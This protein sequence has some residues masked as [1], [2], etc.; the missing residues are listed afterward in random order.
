MAYTGLMVLPVDPPPS[1]PS[2]A[3]SA[4]LEGLSGLLPAK[5]TRNWWLFGA[6]CLGASA[7]IVGG[8]WLA[9]KP[10]AALA[11][12]AVLAGR[13]VEAEIDVRQLGPSGLELGQLRLGSIESPTV[14]LENAQ[15]HWFWNKDKGQIDVRLSS[16]GGLK[17]NI[18][19]GKG[20]LDLGALGPLLESDATGR[21]PVF[22]ETIKIDGAEVIVATQQGPI[23][24]KVDVAGSQDN[25]QITGSALL[26][27][28]LTG[29]SG[30]Q[31][32]PLS[33]VVR[34]LPKA[35]IA[36][37][38]TVIGFEARPEG[39]VYDR[40]GVS[41]GAVTGR[42]AGGVR[43]E[44]GTAPIITLKSSQLR[45]G[46]FSGF[47]LT[48]AN[49]SLDLSSLT[50]TQADLWQTRAS[51][52]LD[53]TLTA[54]RA[55]YAGVTAGALR[56][57]FKAARSLDA[58]LT[59]TYDLSA[60]L[61][62]VPGGAIDS[63]GS[64]R[65]Q[66]TAEGLLPDIAA[67]AN[68]SL[69]FT[70]SLAINRLRLAR[71][72]IATLPEP[73]AAVIGGPVAVQGQIDG[74]YKPGRFEL[75]LAAPMQF[76]GT[77]HSGVFRPDRSF[78]SGLVFEAAGE[79]EA[80]GSWS[81]TGGLRGDLEG[82]ASGGSY[83]ARIET[84]RITEGLF[85]LQLGPVRWDRLQSGGLLTSG[86]LQNG[87]LA[88]A[89]GRISGQG[90]GS[91]SASGR[92]PD[93]SVIDGLSGQFSGQ[94]DANRW[95]GRFDGRIGSFASR[96]VDA[97]NSTGLSVSNVK[98]NANLNGRRRPNGTMLAEVDADAT[99]ETLQFGVTR[100]S[101]AT[102]RTR[103]QAGSG[104]DLFEGQT[105]F[106]A[107]RVTSPDLSSR[108]IAVSGP[109]SIRSSNGGA[110]RIG[111]DLDGRA[112][113]TSTSAGS[114]ATSTVRADGAMVLEGATTT[115]VIRADFV[116]GD[117]RQGTNRVREIT[118]SNRFTLQAGRGSFS[119]TS[120]SG[121]LPA[122]LSGISA[123]EGT[124]GQVGLEICPEPGRPLLSMGGNRTRLA[125][126]A[127]ISPLDLQL[128]ANADLPEGLRQS[129]RLGPSRLRVVDSPQGQ[130]FVLSTTSLEYLLPLEAGVAASGP[131]EG[132]ASA[133]VP[134][135]APRRLASV[136]SNDANVEITPG[137]GGVSIVATLNNVN[138]NGLPVN[139][140]GSATANLLFSEAGLTGSFTLD[141]IAVSDPQADPAFGNFL[142]V[143]SGTLAPD[144]I[145]LSGQL[146]ETRT[147]S[148]VAA[149]TLSHVI[150]TARGGLT[151]DLDAL[152]FKRG[153]FPGAEPGLQPSDI[154]PRLRGLIVN[155][156][157]DVAGT[158]A[159]EW[160]PQK[161]LQTGADLVLD[162][163]TFSTLAGPVTGLSGRIAF[164]DLLTQRTNG[165][166]TITIAEFNPGVPM[167]EGQ[168]GFSLPGN[169]SL[170]V[171][172][173]TWPFAGGRLYIEPTTLL[174]SDPVQRFDVQVAEIDLNRFLRLTEIKDLEVTGTASGRFP[175]VL[176]DGVAAIRGGYLEA[177]GR[178]GGVRYTGVDPS[179]PPPPQTWWQRLTGQPP[180]PPQGIGL[181]VAAL[182]NLDYRVLR[183]TVD[184]RLTGDID[185]GVALEGNNTDVL[186]GVPFKF[187]VN[188]NVPFGRLLGLRRY[189]DPQFYWDMTQEAQRLQGQP[190]A[191]A[192]PAAT[193]QPAP[194][195]IPQSP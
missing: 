30:S 121:C 24:V 195:V 58:A 72:Q 111:F 81:Y 157:G 190:A 62:S 163:L 46:A 154:S 184:G 115:G 142:L 193:P 174:F 11:V 149:L 181:A 166:Q 21:S 141:G 50:W 31:N 10:L 90:S 114:A 126:S 3:P 109:V 33:V 32:V 25:V 35:G 125:L 183:V 54:D 15:A 40:D 78:A 152:L 28:T 5:R 19:L 75:G 60:G 9:R 14:V 48:A 51:F 170:T 138:A 104:A 91:L 16:L 106:T 131:V 89:N 137:D 192:P 129:L 44:S 159:I 143:G 167:L 77:G 52:A 37:A 84:A 113:A 173:A 7:V 172:S 162:G 117:V 2:A 93:G 136:S 1:K 160:D 123:G 188:A 99:A 43:L 194:V 148:P 155:A 144:T 42:L 108:D 59:A 47:G 102:L 26:A 161:P 186:S 187:K 83:A 132:E 139:A 34:Q 61:L 69:G 177:D 53:A 165:V 112:G 140:Q 76:S 180:P 68:I 168:V 85:A 87:N 118:F 22:V 29:A 107:G 158:V 176:E 55:S 156:M 116:L 189:I 182:R 27:Q 185:V 73:L 153:D 101:R 70:S 133:P 179:P 105:W 110:V 150:S 96:V 41:A 71:A 124:I 20:G 23:V 67:P 100:L 191:P 135:P 65:F 127:N 8:I 12:E 63:I 130:R 4:Q 164:A 134:P 17:V 36:G 151:A 13:G 147:G 119:I 169:N 56:L 98:A 88:V 45:L 64:V 95:Q 80:D 175:M 38:S 122:R 6:T 86:S 94:F 82:S 146:S 49:A 74:A 57:P 79:G 66:G 97:G 145:S 178:G 103:G 39:L 120:Q 171:D 18:A 92:L 128:A